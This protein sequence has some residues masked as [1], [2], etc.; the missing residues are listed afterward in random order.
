[1]GS[2]LEV[3]SSEAS[4]PELTG[5][6]SDSSMGAAT[7]AVVFWNHGLNVLLEAHRVVLF[8]GVVEVDPPPSRC[9]VLP[10]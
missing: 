8:W 2:A 1:M 3:D 10:R 4:N 7:K 9:L 5:V 6:E